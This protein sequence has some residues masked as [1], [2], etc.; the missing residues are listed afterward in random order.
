L[1][2]IVN[3]IN[4]ID[5]QATMGVRN[6][7]KLIFT[8]CDFESLAL[9]W[10]A[11]GIGRSSSVFCAFKSG[12]GPHAVQNLAEHID[13]PLFAIAFWNAPVPCAFFR[14]KTTC[15][16]ALLFKLSTTEFGAV[17]NLDYGNMSPLSDR[18]T[19]LPV[20]KRGRARALQI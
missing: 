18:Q 8:R 13:A 20:P 6:R 1:Q 19:C 3:K 16:D 4:R 7:R 11:S 17:A 12:G 10:V 2:V 15:R 9:L 5:F 14:K